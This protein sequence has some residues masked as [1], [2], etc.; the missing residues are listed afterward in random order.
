MSA[1]KQ[2]RRAIVTGASMGIG[3]AVAR[4]FARDGA[5]V[6]LVARNR[7]ELDR[8]AA[9]I[10]KDGGRAFPCA[11]DL[12]DRGAARTI[13]DTALREMGGVDMLVNC[14]SLTRNEDFFE[15][16]DDHWLNGF[17]VK[18]FAA[19]R[20]CREA[21]PALKQGRGSIVNIG[22][23]GARTPHPGS[24]MSAA[25]SSALAAVTKALAVT[26]VADG[27]QVNAIHPGLVRTPRIERTF[28]AGQVSD[29]DIDAM[30][31]RSSERIGAVRP[32]RAEDVAS[33][34][35]YI[36]SPAGEMLQGSIIDLDGGMTKGI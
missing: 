27:V 10:R 4:R 21:W 25:S 7:A 26:G 31:S 17:E 16:S 19:I 14:A 29:T 24:V 36:M 12:S 35:A 3:E 28:A 9:D 15:L 20:L 33:L 6:V 2:R 1:V 11:V 22:G 34:V 13:V 8:V 23:V 5:Q 18:V 30:L 32:G